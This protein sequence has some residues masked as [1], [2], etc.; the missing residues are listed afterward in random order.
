MSVTA[1]RD[2]TP[3]FGSVA[4]TPAAFRAAAALLKRNWRYGE[5]TMVLPSG[6]EIYL[7][8]QEPGASGVILIKD[9][10]FVRRVLAG[11]DIGFGEGFMAEEWDSP[12][13][14]GLLEALAANLDDLQRLLNGNPIVRAFNALAHAKRKNSRTGSRK[15][16]EAHY[17]LGN[18]FYE[19]WLDPSMTYSSALYSAPG[20]ALEAAQ[21][22]KYANLAKALELKPGCTVLEI[23]CGWGGFAE[24]AARECGAHV[25]GITLSQEQHAFAKARLLKAGLADRTDIRLVDYRDVSGRF[26]RVASIEMFEAVGEEYWPTFFGRVRD[27]L[28]PGGVAG[29]QVITIADA[30]FEH[31]RGQADFIQKYVFPGGMLPSEGRLKAQVEGAGLTWMPIARFGE[32]YADTLAQW[33][34]RFRHAWSDVARLGFDERFRRLWLFYLGY[35]EAG[36]RTG[37]INVMQFTAARAP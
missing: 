33:T 32:H 19:R 15:N 24:Y 13:L 12:D 11:G 34:E 14:A 21:A 29:L 23:G 36:F 5:L 37:R 9:F 26:D 18:A 2:L 25:T 7:V 10:R 35:C 6:E 20:Q 27:L 31:Y 30:L 1:S 4:R 17:D 16:I 3:A 28:K 8:G 22:N